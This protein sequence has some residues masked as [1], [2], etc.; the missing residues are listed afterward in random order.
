[1][2]RSHYVIRGGLDGRERLRILARVMYPTTHALLQRVGLGQGMACLDVGCGGGDVTFEIARLVGP[3]GRVAGVD[4]D[5]TKIGLARNEAAALS[6][7]NVDF[8]VTEIQGSG[9]EAEFDLVY[10]RFLLTHLSDPD[11]ALT[12]M[13][14]LL[15]PGGV[16][17]VEDVDFRGH[18]CHP[19][20]PAFQRYVELY[21]QAVRRRGADPD[22]GPRLPGL[23]LD[24][25]YRGVQM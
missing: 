16:I 23:L 10:A 22:I 24:A 12:E 13:R 17:V 9:R 25:G 11:G 4:I 18:F 2:D 8:R 21:T 1:M 15:R 3:E 20:S 19:E 5:E 6:L 14:R 7:P